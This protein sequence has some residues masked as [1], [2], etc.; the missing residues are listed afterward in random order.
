MGWEPQG[1]RSGA[2]SPGWP[3]SCEDLSFLSRVML[4]YFSMFLMPGCIPVPSNH[5]PTPRLRP[6]HLYF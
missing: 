1:G 3:W 4:R 2:A 5:T 6:K